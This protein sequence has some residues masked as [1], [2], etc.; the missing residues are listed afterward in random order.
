MNILIVGPS[1]VGDMVM[2]QTLFQ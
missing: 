1:W 2:A